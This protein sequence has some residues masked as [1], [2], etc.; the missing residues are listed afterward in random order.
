[1][2]KY[3]IGIGSFVAN[4]FYKKNKGKWN[5]IKLRVKSHFDIERELQNFE[6][7]K[8]KDKLFDNIQRPDVFASS[9]RGDCDDFANFTFMLLNYLQYEAYL[10]GI[11]KGTT[12]GHAITVF[13]FSD[14]WYFFSNKNCYG[15]FKSFDEAV[16]RFYGDNTRIFE[17]IKKGDYRYAY[18]SISGF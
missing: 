7:T 16:K 4:L 12:E 9:C 6:Y 17:V 3:L 18:N 5:E 15:C 2:Y 14:T 10:V 1:M 8:S 13:Y 11:W